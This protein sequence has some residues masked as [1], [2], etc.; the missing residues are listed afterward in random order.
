MDS[1]NGWIC[2]TTDLVNQKTVRRI[3]YKIEV[4]VGTEGASVS[5]APVIPKSGEF[6]L[7]SSIRIT[8]INNHQ[9]QWCDCGFVAQRCGVRIVPPRPTRLPQDMQYSLFQHS[10][11]VEPIDSH[12]NKSGTRFRSQGCAY[13][14]CARISQFVVRFVAK[15][16]S[17]SV[18]SPII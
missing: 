16:I 18:P 5:T 6:R 3:L 1:E 2:V 12:R 4:F 17:R 9:Q 7:K 8:P 10:E 14:P 13:E 11:E 15:V